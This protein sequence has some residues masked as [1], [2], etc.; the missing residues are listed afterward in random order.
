MMTVDNNEQKLRNGLHPHGQ[1]VSFDKRETQ[2]DTKP[3]HAHCTVEIA[4]VVQIATL[5][6]DILLC[7]LVQVGPP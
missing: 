5:K 7:S 4:F 2:D 6:C 1:T 3:L